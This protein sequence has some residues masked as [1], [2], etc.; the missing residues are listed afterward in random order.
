MGSTK[1]Q[2]LSLKQLPCKPQSNS[3]LSLKPSYGHLSLKLQQL[4]L[5]QLPLKPLS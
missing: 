5:K 3:P 2:Q 1:R 4:P